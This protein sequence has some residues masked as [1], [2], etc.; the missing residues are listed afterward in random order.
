MNKLSE[1]DFLVVGGDPAGSTVASL[2]VHRQKHVGSDI[3]P[4]ALG[5]ES[6]LKCSTWAKCLEVAG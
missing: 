4:K 3:S 1:C 5:P 6:G 2:L